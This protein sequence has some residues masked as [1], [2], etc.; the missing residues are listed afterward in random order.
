MALV[1]RNSPAN[2]GDIRDEGLITWLGRYLG[3]RHGN[4]LQDSCLGFLGR[5]KPG[6]L[7]STESQSISHD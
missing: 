2:A 4:S 7:Q 6:T 3:G 1:V 5:E